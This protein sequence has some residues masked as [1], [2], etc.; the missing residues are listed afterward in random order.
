MCMSRDQEP[1]LVSAFLHWVFVTRAVFN[2]DRSCNF[3]IYFSSCCFRHVRLWIRSKAQVFLPLPYL[4]LKTKTLKG[5]HGHPSTKPTV[6]PVIHRLL[7]FL[8][9]AKF[10]VLKQSSGSPEKN[11][12]NC[13][14]LD[15]GKTSL[16]L[17]VGILTDSPQLLTSITQTCS[18]T[19]W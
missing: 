6:T 12:K 1:D 15:G 7:G 5:L 11:S 2:H 16:S 10:N 4:G 18:N 9:A 19:F 17:T 3:K 13:G 8:A 14:D